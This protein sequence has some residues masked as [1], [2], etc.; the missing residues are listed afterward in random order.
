L[1]KN[2]ILKYLR[3]IKKLKLIPAMSM[4]FKKGGAATTYVNYILNQTSQNTREGKTI[5]PLKKTIF[6]WNAYPRLILKI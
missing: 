5:I 4:G 2:L 3:T 1:K 6:S